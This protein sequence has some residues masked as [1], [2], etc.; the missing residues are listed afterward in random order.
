ML[1]TRPTDMTYKYVNSE[2]SYLP[3]YDGDVER[4]LNAE[5]REGWKV[6]DVHYYESGHVKMLLHR[7][8]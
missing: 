4:V 7:E 6:I 2:V 3:A 5:E 1:S 8:D